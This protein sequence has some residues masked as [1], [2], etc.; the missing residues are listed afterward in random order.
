MARVDVVEVQKKFLRRYTSGCLRKK[1]CYVERIEKTVGKK[2]L[3]S[4]RV[5]FPED[6]FWVQI[7]TDPSVIEIQTKP[8]TVAEYKKSRVHMDR[9]FSV[10]EAVGIKPHSFN[11][12]GHIH[13][14]IKSAFGNDVKLF[15]NF[16]VDF[17]NHQELG[18][19]GVL[20][21]DFQNAPHLS[22][23]EK[24]QRREFRKV[25]G[26]FDSGE[27]N[28]IRE[29]T[30]A[31]NKRVYRGNPA[32][33]GPTEK[34]QALNLLRALLEDGE[35]TVE[36]R[37]IDPQRDFDEFLKQINLFEKRIEFLK[38]ND[39]ILELLDLAK[40]S[41]ADRLSAFRSYVEESKLKWKAYHPIIRNNRHSVFDAVQP[42]SRV[43]WVNKLSSVDRSSA[44]PAAVCERMFSWFMSPSA[45]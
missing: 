34:Y 16:L 37:G 21:G 41:N 27:I 10:G 39:G 15:R 3:I 2:T 32:G 13:M 20:G 25:I 24:F 5:H 9:L 38:K 31:I 7:S 11:G 30:D 28:S 22:E 4:F 12:G 23:L 18:G 1:T 8:S 44:G 36:F 26:E 14:D 43:Q 45:R 33:W 6:N 35:S 17:M 19:D 29:L 40:M 42:K